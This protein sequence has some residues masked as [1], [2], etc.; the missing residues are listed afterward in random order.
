MYWQVEYDSDWLPICEI[1]GKS[2]RKLWSHAYNWHQIKARDYKI[3][4][5]L[6]VKKW[7][8]CAETIKILQEHSKANYPIVVE[9]NL[10]VK[11][12]DSRF[13]PWTKWKKAYVSEQTKVMLRTKHLKK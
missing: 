4:F 1:C 7:I 9:E 13:T 6:D 10:L 8:C 12:V 11:W 2:F 5:W 3:M